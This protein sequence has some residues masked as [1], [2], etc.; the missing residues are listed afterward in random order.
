MG[1]SPGVN[2]FEYVAISNMTEPD[3]TSSNLAVKWVVKD[4]P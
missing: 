4:F 2:G 1:T 3:Y